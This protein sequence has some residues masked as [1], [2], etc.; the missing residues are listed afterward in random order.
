VLN[1]MGFGWWK[2][3]NSDKWIFLHDWWCYRLRQRASLEN[4]IRLTIQQVL[5]CRNYIPLESSFDL[6]S[7]DKE[8]PIPWVMVSI[9]SW[10]KYWLTIKKLFVWN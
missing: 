6:I 5:F 2:N 7:S 1:K 10:E 8:W 9:K 4:L 3:R